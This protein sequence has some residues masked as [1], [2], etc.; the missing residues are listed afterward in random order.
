MKLAVIGAGS[1]Y[2]PELV[3][4]LI[5]RR[6]DFPIETL[7]LMD[8]NH[9][10]LRT[11][12]SFVT[13]MAEASGARFAIEMHTRLRDVL[14]GADFVVTQIRVGGQLWRN[15]DCKLAMEHG[16]VGQE[17]TGFAGFAKAIRTIPQILDICQAMRLTSPDAW[18]INFTNPSGIITEAIVRHGGVRVIGLCNV[19]INMKL[20]IARALAVPADEISRDY[21]GLN[22]LSWIRKVHWLS[23][24]VT[25]RALAIAA[26]SV[27]ANI[28]G[29]P[30]TPKLAEALRMAPSPYLRYFYRTG[31]SIAEQKSSPQTR[32]DVVMEIEAK[33]M[34]SYGDPAL[35]RKPAI[36]AKRGGAHYSTIAIDIMS[37]IYNNSGKVE[38]VDIPHSGAVHGFPPSAVME[39][40]AAIDASGAHP[41]HIGDVEPEIRGLMHQVK[42]YEELTIEAAVDG[43][44]SKALLA[45]VNNPLVRDADKAENLLDALIVSGRASLQ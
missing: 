4:G 22:H 26:S 25:D 7:S 45:L 32:A 27:Q 29:A 11:V 37:S 18:L 9:E 24:D 34:Q 23:K 44:Y 33:L 3:D 19:P 10:R 36:L 5:R 16:L 8:I 20:E 12:G 41:I 40:P 42:A 38:I 1:T 39:I 30:V 21:V 43:S 6:R 31:D 13:R 2:T 15:L 17:T 14:A 35:T 28:S